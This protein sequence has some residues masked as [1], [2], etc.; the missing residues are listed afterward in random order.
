MKMFLP[1]L[2]S[3]VCALPS[4]VAEA[5]RT[6]IIRDSKGAIVERW[7]WVKQA[8]GSRRVTV[9]DASGKLLRVF[10]LPAFR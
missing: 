4:L 7:T 1:V 3:L 9:R 6:D 10:V 2:A 5:P 8:D